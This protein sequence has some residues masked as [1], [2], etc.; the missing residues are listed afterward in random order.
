LLLDDP[1]AEL[2]ATAIDRFMN[3]VFA[4]G[5]QLLLTSLPTQLSGLSQRS[6]VFHVEQGRIERVV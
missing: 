6:R 1:A 2:D 4:L 5:A 3:R